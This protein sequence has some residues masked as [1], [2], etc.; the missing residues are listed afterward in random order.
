MF[1]LRNLGPLR[2][3]DPETKEIKYRDLGTSNDVSVSCKQQMVAEK[4]EP[5]EKSKNIYTRALF[6]SG[7][8]DSRTPSHSPCSESRVCSPVADTKEKSRVSCLRLQRQQL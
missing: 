4:I 7:V 1:L 2:G 6:E 8:A 3:R 5:K